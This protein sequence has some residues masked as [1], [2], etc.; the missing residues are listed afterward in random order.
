MNDTRYT[1]RAGRRFGLAAAVGAGMLAL[2]ACDGLLDV[3]LPGEMTEE[4]LFQSQSAG[5][6]VDSAIADFECS[7]SMMS[8][9]MSGGEDATWKTS[10]YFTTTTEH[11]TTRPGGGSCT[12]NSDVGTNF[13]QGFQKSRFLA[14][15]AYDHLQEWPDAEVPNRAQLLATSATYVGL[16]FT[17]TGETYCEFARAEGPIMT[18]MQVLQEAEEWYTRALGHMGSGDF[19]IVSTES[20]RQ[21]ALLGRARARLAMG[22]HSGAAADASQIEPGFVAYVTRDSSVRG[23]WNAPYQAFNATRWRTVAGPMWWFGHDE[24]LMVSAGYYDLTISPDG[25]QTVND[26]VLDPRVPVE[27]T[28]EFAQ[29][30]VTDQWNQQKYTSLGQDEY[31]AR[32]AEAQLILA[33]VE[34]EQ[35]S[36]QSTVDRI[37]TL[38]DVH[39]LPH[40]SSTDE[41]EIWS[42]LIEER[43]REFFME[44]GRHYADKLRYGLWFPRGRGWNH[45]TVRYGLG[46]CMLMPTDAYELNPNVEPGYEGPDLSDLNY[47]FQLTIDRPIELGVDWPVPASLDFDYF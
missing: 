5:M 20:L 30:G 29:D 15:A 24:D 19:S 1:R 7:Y 8:A 40:F 11:Q 13:F 9:I 39:G 23:R 36:P 35:G 4:D 21:L 46:Y 18:P 44:G 45:K 27:F 42:A 32:W 37:N 25:R 2:A 31:L 12:G 43:R 47:T 3:E 34:F 26:G 17:W 38:R 14:E 10:G 33:E 28:G 6:I 41:R 16:F 22:D